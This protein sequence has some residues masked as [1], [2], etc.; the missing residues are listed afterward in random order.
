MTTKEG[1][2]TAE[3]GSGKWS[4]GTNRNHSGRGA[5]VKHDQ[6]YYARGEGRV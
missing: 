6:G 3:P 1:E 5:M 4:K 2:P